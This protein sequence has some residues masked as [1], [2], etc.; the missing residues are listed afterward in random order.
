M[1][2]IKSIFKSLS[3]LYFLVLINGILFTSM[4]YFK[5]ES[6]YESEI[7]SAISHH[8]VRD[9]AGKNNVDSFFIRAMS[10]THL[11]EHNR[12]NVFNSQKIE[13]LKANLFH[14]VTMDLITGNGSCGSA[15][16]ILARTLKSYNFKVRF[17]QMLVDGK[18]GGHIVIEV[19]KFGKWIVMDPLFNLYF[20]DSSN[21][22]A[23]FEE[24]SKHFDYYKKQ[25]PPN[26]P[27]S[28]KYEAAQYTNWNK[29]KFIG[30][31]TKSAL[32]FT[33]GKEKADKISLRA[34]LLRGYNILYLIT[35]FVFIIVFAFT[36]WKFWKQNKPSKIVA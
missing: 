19:N 15:S 22:F 31:I 30:P 12:I 34:Y 13:G 2:I 25:L 1:K 35:R 33:M 17:V 10:I 27:A 7:F 9:S 20:K 16:A 3:N 18:Y 29:I 5:I 23:S 14:P 6:T 8:I 28:Y 26:Y 4:I 24:V 32:N 11:F 21:N 36:I